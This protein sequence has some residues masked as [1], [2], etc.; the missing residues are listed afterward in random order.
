VKDWL[1]GP[2]LVAWIESRW[3]FN[4]RQ[5]G[6]HKVYL[7]EWRAGNAACVY[8]ADR[9]LLRLGLHLSEVPDDLFLESDLC[10]SAYRS[11]AA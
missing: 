8:V 1:D 11:E 10:P 6:G 4:F 7:R 9:V 5:L 3:E 2:A